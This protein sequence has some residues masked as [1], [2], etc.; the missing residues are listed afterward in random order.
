MK[1]RAAGFTLIEVLVATT[2]LIVALASLAQLFAV[3]TRTNATAK[4]TSI[5][6]LLAE[7]KMEQLR[8]LEWGFDTLGLPLSDNSTD[9]AIVPESATGGTG[10]SPSPSGALSANTPGFVD[11]L[12]P[13]GVSFGGGSPTPPAGAVYTRRWSI[14]PLPASPNDTLVLQVLVTPWRD[15]GVADTAIGVTRL[16]RE[17]RLV[18]V[19]T[20]KAN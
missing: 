5:A 6:L 15:R 3:S 4:A 14:E 18:S 16:P 7:E 8:S 20:R 13:N 19:K 10:L 2:I 12:G 17:A 9:T 11:Y 1:A